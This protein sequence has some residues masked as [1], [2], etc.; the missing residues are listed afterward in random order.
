[1]A[2][3][4]KNSLPHD[5][6][7]LTVERRLTQLETQQ[8]EMYRVFGEIKVGMASIQ[9]SIISSNATDSTLKQTVDNLVLD[10]GAIKAQINQLDTLSFFSKNPKLLLYLAVGAVVIFVPQIR[11]GLANLLLNKQ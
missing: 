4:S 11:E 7:D 1:M 6:I 3:S 8:I 2:S 10:V 9:S 5:T